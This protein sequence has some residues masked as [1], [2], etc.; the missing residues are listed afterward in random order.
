LEINIRGYSISKNKAAKREEGDR[1]K[2]KKKDRER[3][4]NR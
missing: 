2:K 4:N 3:N 1:Y